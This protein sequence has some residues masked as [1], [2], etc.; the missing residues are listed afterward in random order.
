MNE[1]VIKV[2]AGIWTIFGATIMGFVIGYF[3]R[4]AAKIEDDQLRALTLEVVADVEA[5][6]GTY[7][8]STAASLAEKPIPLEVSRT[9]LSFSAEKKA[10]AIRRLLSQLPVDSL[11]HADAGQLIEWAVAEANKNKK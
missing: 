7:N 10:E 1:T 3:R 11:T 5:W 4:H 8:M 6:A 2:M 9:A